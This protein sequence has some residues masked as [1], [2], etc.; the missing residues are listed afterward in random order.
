MNAETFKQIFLPYHQ[1]LFRIAY[2]LVGNAECAEDMLQDSFVKLWEKR[3]QL[4]QV[5]NTEAFAIVT[6]RN[7]CLDYLR[8]QK[9]DFLLFEQSVPETESLP[10]QIEYQDEAQK[11]K[12]YLSRLPQNQQTVMK[13]KHWDGLTDEEIEQ[14]TG[15]SQGNIR[16]LLSRGRTAIRTHFN[17]LR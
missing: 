10:E 2:R 1:K 11:V 9:E 3:E 7:T 15:Y 16:V 6:L 17:K 8:K 12:Q 4:A 14:S 13:L 5:A